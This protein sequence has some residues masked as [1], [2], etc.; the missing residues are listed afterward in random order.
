MAEPGTTATGAAPATGAATPPA[1]PPAAAVTPPEFDYDKLAQLVAGKQTVTEE[2]VLK[3]YFKQQGLSKEQ[4]DQAIAAYKQQQ[5]ANQPDVAAIQQQ[6]VQAQAA[7]Q[8]AMLDKEATLAA[9]GLGLDA[10]TIPYVLKMADLSQVMGQDGKINEETLKT[11]LN[12]VLE[13]VPALKPQASGST[14]FIQVGAASGGQ[15]QQTVD[16][17]LDRI[18]GVKKK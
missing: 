5:A 15:T 2:S 12:K 18:F 6:A 9:I 8:Q 16:T 11:A 7:A 10:K 3:G 4:M 14:G 17:E 1:T 13:D